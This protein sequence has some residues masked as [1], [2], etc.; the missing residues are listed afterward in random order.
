VGKI[1]ILRKKIIFF[2]I[3]EGGAKFVGVFR[4]ELMTLGRNKNDKRGKKLNI[5][6]LL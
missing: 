4:V 1:T 5:S 6:R 3:T 2:P